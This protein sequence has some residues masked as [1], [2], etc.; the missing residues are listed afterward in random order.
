MGRVVFQL[1][2]FLTPEGRVNL[3]TAKIEADGQVEST[4]TQFEAAEVALERAQRLLKADAGSR[5]AVDEAQEKYGVAKQNAA[6]AV[7]RRDQLQKAVGDLDKGTVSPL[8]IECPQNGVLRNLSAS[9]G[10]TVPSGAALFEVVNLDRLWVR[11]PVYVGDRPNIDAAAEAA[12]VALSA[13]PG[14]AG[15]PVKPVAAPPSANAAAG[16]VDLYYELDNRKAKLCP[17]ERVGVRMPL[18]GDSVA[19]TLPWSAV[20]H[21]LYGGTWVYEQTG[22]RT[23][24]RRRVAVRFV[25]GERAVLAAGP[26]EG[27]RVVV[28]GAAELFG[29]ETGFSK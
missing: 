23:Y 3:T 2:P 25:D 20:V 4:R 7:A 22:E 10:Q 12:V 14:E 5:R 13:G 26:A 1:F 24:A 8:T 28:A 15:Q 29:T 17:G 21:D 27:T 19:L 16:T 18:Q 9:P 6:M 11:V